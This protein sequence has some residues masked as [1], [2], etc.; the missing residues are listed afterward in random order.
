MK[1]L[2][3]HYSTVQLGSFLVWILKRNERDTIACEKMPGNTSFFTDITK[4]YCSKQ[5]VHVLHISTH[6]CT[7]ARCRMPTQAILTSSCSDL[8]NF[9]FL[10]CCWE[11]NC[12]GSVHP[13]IN[14]FKVDVNTTWL[15]ER[16]FVGVCSVLSHFFF[17]KTH[18]H[19]QIHTSKWCVCFR[20]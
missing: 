9:M 19:M 2:L 5:T 8:W 20:S 13:F 1:V 6:T 14:C 3:E 4:R 15:A 7:Y 18:I 17:L 11:W 16:L 10:M 12:S